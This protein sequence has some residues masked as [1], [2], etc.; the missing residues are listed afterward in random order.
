M[1]LLL[2]TLCFWSFAVK[3]FKR[4]PCFN[5]SIRFAGADPG[6]SKGGGGGGGGS[7]TSADSTSFSGSLGTC[8]PE[9]FENLNLQN[10]H[11]QNFETNFVFV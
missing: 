4:V 9:C 6:L 7:I 2:I 5:T 10:G 11:F 3:Y 8:V 1:F